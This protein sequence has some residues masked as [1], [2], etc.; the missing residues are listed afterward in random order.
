MASVWVSESDPARTA[1]AVAGR[2]ASRCAVSIVAR[3]RPTVVPDTC[4]IHA[5]TSRNSPSGPTH[6]PV[7]ATRP[8]ASVSPAPASRFSSANC[9]TR[10][11]ASAPANAAG[12]SDASTRRA[13][14]T[15]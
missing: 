7:C 12:S 5:P 8:A 6:A 13:C 2:A 1:A 4:A 14:T 11:F 15:S 3:A 9:S 10:R